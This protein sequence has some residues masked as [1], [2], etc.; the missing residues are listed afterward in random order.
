M[1]I[2]FN[3]LVLLLC[4]GAILLIALLSYA[5]FLR[6]PKQSQPSNVVMDSSPADIQVQDAPQP[7]TGPFAELAYCRNGTVEYVQAVRAGQTSFIGT[8]SYPGLGSGMP[9][10]CIEVKF[11]GD[12]LSC[13]NLDWQTE[14]SIKAVDGAES[15][16]PMNQV[17]VL[18][19]GDE[20]QLPNG[21][22]ICCKINEGNAQ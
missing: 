3:W 15:V 16:L 17:N 10:R 11:T 6:G 20:L 4:L 18:N 19:S 13:C 1:E 7:T 9:V 22:T 12:S 2:V 21:W 14:V 8:E 5:D